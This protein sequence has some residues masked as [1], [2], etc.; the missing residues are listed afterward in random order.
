MRQLLFFVL[1]GLLAEMAYSQQDT[2]TVLPEVEVSE[3]V[4]NTVLSGVYTQE[5]DSIDKIG[6][7]AANLGDVLTE[8]GFAI[9]RNYGNMQL[10]TLS[11][12]GA[13]A[14][15]TAVCWEGFPL[16]DCKKI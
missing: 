3:T 4:F 12:G 9:I 15:Q 13:T 16:N 11:L 7:I 2:L 6:S 1:F 10:Q 8:K 14:S 5:T